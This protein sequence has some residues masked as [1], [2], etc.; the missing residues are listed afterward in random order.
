MSVSWQGAPLCRVNGVGGVRY[1]D[2]ALKRP[3][4]SE[5]LD[6]VADATVTI[7]EYMRLLEK[8]PALKA[9]GLDGSYKLLNEFNGAVLAAHHSSRQGWQFVTWCR[10]YSGEGVT[11]GH[12]VGGDY[13]GAKRDFAVRA[14]LVPQSQLFSQEQLTEIH[15]CVDTVRD[16]DIPMTAEREQRMEGIL[17]QIK[18][19]VPDLDARIGQ[20][21]NADGQIADQTFGSQMM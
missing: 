11:Q 5:A 8:A 20:A 17:D 12:Y 7:A 13:E 19:A 3:G 10:D 18:C 21:Q 4:A 15:R 6:R 2:E 16:M 1:R 14:G 9:N